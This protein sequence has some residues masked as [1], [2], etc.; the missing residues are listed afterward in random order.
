MIINMIFKFIFYFIASI[1]L[2]KKDITVINWEWWVIVF[3]LMIGCIIPL[4]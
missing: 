3:C 2:A 1:V 4:Q